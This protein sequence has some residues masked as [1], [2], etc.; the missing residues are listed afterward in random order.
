MRDIVLP[1]LEKEIN[2]GAHFATLRQIYQAL[3]LSAWFKRKLKENALNKAYSDQNKNA[4]LEFNGVNEEAIYQQYIEAYREGAFNFIREEKAA[5]EDTPIPRKYFSGGV[6][7]DT[8][9]L[10][11]AITFTDN[12]QEIISGDT[13]QQL[14]G[15]DLAQASKASTEKDTDRFDMISRQLDK[16][17][18][19]SG[20]SRTRGIHQLVKEQLAFERQQQRKHPL[21]YRF[22]ASSERS[23][24]T[25]QIIIGHLKSTRFYPVHR[26]EIV[27]FILALSLEDAALYRWLLRILVDNA[28][29]QR[30]DE[31]TTDPRMIARRIHGEAS[32]AFL[33]DLLME[34]Q[35]T[36]FARYNDMI[37]KLRS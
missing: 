13:P 28:L 8:Q 14:F 22:A 24:G 1:A 6:L 11:N 12:T 21:L 2:E 19:L 5:G 3:I 31:K 23:K 32:L 9:Q 18:L 33:K 25:L 7:A 37:F 4:G 10:D 17:S 29:Y 26:A 36:D 34:L 27:D 15:I 20:E 35:R 16:I 30:S